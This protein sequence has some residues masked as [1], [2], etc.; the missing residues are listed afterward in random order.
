[1]DEHGG[2]ARPEG[3][4]LRVG[5]DARWYNDSGVGTYVAELLRALAK[6]RE[7]ELI[8]YESPGNPV[9]T[10]DGQQATRVPLQAA[11]YSPAEQL[12]MARLCRKDRL[13]V[14]HSPFYIAPL[15]A[16][17]PVVVTIHDL[18]PFLF[19]VYSWP[20]AA[21]V[22]GGYRMAVRKA[23]QIITVSQTTAR[24][25]QEILGVNP[26]RI[27]A[28]LSAVDRQQFHERKDGSELKRLEEQF[29]VR[30]PY[31]VAASA[32]NWR[33]KNL[34]GALQ[35][36]QLARQQSGVPF[37]TVVYGPV[38]GLNAA[39][40][41]GRWADI[42]LRHTGYMASDDLG[43]LFRHAALFI[44]PSLYEGFG[45]PILEAMSCGCAVITSNCGS[46]AEVAGSGAQVFP[47]S[48]ISGMASA[49]CGLLCNPEVLSRWRV[50]ALRRAAEFSWEKAARETISVYYR[51]VKQTYGCS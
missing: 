48:E 12:Q 2:R 1:M 11:K 17:C 51:V 47:P 36:L 4:T 5:F 41:T 38:E 14:F 16:P 37:Q 28:V 15:A 18:I 49:V 32:R 46:L 30:P 31:V 8:A 44:M 50:S 33:T 35:A 23:A 24:D 34:P 6:Q 43:T 25:M 26:E 39:G 7:I 10:L 21:M 3:R 9:P 27:T 13:D 40:G 20:K 22:R 19:S 45:L 42:N 29:G